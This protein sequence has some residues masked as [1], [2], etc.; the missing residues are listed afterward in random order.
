M[1][2]D[3]DETILEH[4]SYHEGITGEEAIY[5]LRASGHHLCYLTRYSKLQKSYVLT[6]YQIQQRMNDDEMH[7]KIVIEN[8]RYKIDGTKRDFEDIDHL[9]EFYEEHRIHRTLRKI[10]ERY[11]Q[12]EYMEEEEGH[13]NDHR[14][15]NPQNGNRPAQNR[16]RPVQ[17]PQNGNGPAQPPQNG[18]EP[19]QPH[20]NGNGPAQ[21]PAGAGPPNGNERKWWQKCTIS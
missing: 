7:F 4:P 8:E 6:V 17:P 12:D 10:G 21:P 15:L 1:A 16:N 5:R 19:A 14:E 2:D 3:T 9:L 18:N 13:E 11:T 20:Q